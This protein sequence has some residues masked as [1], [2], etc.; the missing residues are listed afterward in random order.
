MPYFKIFIIFSLQVLFINLLNA[1]D[2]YSKSLN[3]NEEKIFKLSLKSGDQKKWA[4]SIKGIE[5]INDKVAR[6]IIIWRWLIADDG[7][8]SKKDLENFYNTG[9]TW[10]KINKVKAK[11]ESKKVTNDLRKTLDWFQENPPITPIAKIKLSEILIK[12]NFIEEG[13]WLLKEAWVNNSFSY[14][15]EKYILKSYKNIITNSENTKRL[16]NLI[17]KRQWSSANRQL[18]RV[19]SDI[20]QFSI[21]KIKLSRRRGN[22]DQA[23]K[24]VPK[25]LINEESLIYEIVKWRRKARLEKS[26]LELL[27]SYHGEYSYPKKWWKEINYH[28]RK[29]LSYKN[30]KLATKILEQYNL[31]SKDY[32]SEAQWLAGW[33]SLTFN[34]DPKSAYKYFSKMFLE[35]KTPISKARA[36]YWAGKASEELGNRED[37]KIWYERAAAFP[38]TFYGQLALKKLNRELFLPSQNTE[39]D[40]DEFKKFKE[41]ELVRA[42]ILLLQ[43]ENRKLSRIFAMHLVTQA[44]NTKDILMLSKILNDFNQVSFSIFVGKK[45]IYNNIYIPS[46]NFPVPN[47][48]LMN[49]INK[50]TEIPLP[51]TLAITRQESA[52]DV[53]AKSRAGARGLMQLMP[54][55]ARITAKKNNYKYKRIYLTSRPAYN[56]RIGSFYFKEMLNKFNGSYVLALAA[57][58][59]GPSRVNRW[60][61]IY[62][63][64]RK[65]EIDPVTW[66]ELIPI[67]E[68]RNYVQRVIEGIYMYRMLVKNEKNLTSPIK[69]LKL[70]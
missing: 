43:V 57:Y 15:E 62:G 33:L 27:L 70:F 30:Y 4:R 35:V 32:L 21:A 52:F 39:F 53:K 63:D 40:Q 60:L 58:N 19:S 55:T 66:M 69:Q 59:A 49:L 37:L 67:S 10:P 16:E 45:A 36:S 47:T 14:S 18:K 29:Q 68:T 56:V 22:V 11:I 34:K 3:L 44:K 48:E 28:T 65:N 41:N 61:K 5:K 9:I 50:N 12:N 25:S 38:A 31:S 46:L 2:K 8:S 64:P 6:K 7:V 23:I 13:N 51:V 24:N 20:K 17:W 1:D 26:S 54:R 42:L